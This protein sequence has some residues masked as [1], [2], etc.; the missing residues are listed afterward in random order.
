MKKHI[1]LLLLILVTATSVFAQK[2]GPYKI[3]GIRI[4]PFDEVEGKFRDTLAPDDI[5][6]W[7]NDLSM[8]ILAVIEL[9]G[10]AGSYGDKRTVSIRVMEGRKL[11]VSKI[12]YPGVFSDSG[13][14]YVPVWINGSVCDNLTITATMLGQTTKSSMTRKLS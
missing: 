11:K 1:A 13:H 10:A 9:T 8:S 7:G 6:G 4:M 2:T 12:G 5:G 3:T 14:Y